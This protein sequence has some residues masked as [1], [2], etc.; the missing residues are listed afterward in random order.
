MRDERSKVW[1][2]TVQTRLFLRLGAYWLISQIALWNLV[3]VWRL[4]QEGPG[5]PVEQYGRFLT[6][7]A[8]ALIGSVVLL[9]ILV[10]DTIRFAHRVVGPLYRLR[11]TMQALAAGEAVRPIRLRKDDFLGEV[12]DDFNCMLEALQRKGVPVLKPADPPEQM[13]QA[14]PTRAAVG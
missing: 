7:F 1:I 2:H 9:P 11:R 8:P 10:W 6:D 3:F 4:W 13:V 12:R 14:Q 5:D